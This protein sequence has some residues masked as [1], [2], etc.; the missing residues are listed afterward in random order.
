MTS[1]SNPGHGREVLG[2]APARERPHHRPDGVFPPVHR[3]RG[4]FPDLGEVLELT[5]PQV[6]EHLFV[7]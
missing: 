4:G 7:E 5:R 3:L 1:T 2:G 6:F